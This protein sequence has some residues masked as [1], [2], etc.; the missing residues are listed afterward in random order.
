M[1][2]FSKGFI[3]RTGMRIKEIGERVGHVKIRGVFIFSRLSDWI[4][5]KGLNIKE[6]VFDCPISEL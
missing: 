5:R 6:S 4:T 1:R 3:Y 2:I